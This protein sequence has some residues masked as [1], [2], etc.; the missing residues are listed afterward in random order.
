MDF[1]EFLKNLKEEDWAKKINENWTIKD[2]VAHLVGWE[3]ESARVLKD[4]WGSEKDPWFLLDGN[5]EK[6][7]ARSVDFYK[8]YSAEEL[9]REWEKWQGV[10]EGEIKEIGE[11]NL[12]QDPKMN[13][14]FDEEHYKYHLDQIKSSL[15]KSLNIFYAKRNGNIIWR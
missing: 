8:S 2:V 3:K 15:N 1:L 6:F 13:W 12:R 7:N 11:N 5:Y 10:L 9:I 14:V 4:V